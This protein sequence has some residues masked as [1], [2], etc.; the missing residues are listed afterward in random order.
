[1]SKL[2]SLKTVSDSSIFARVMSIDNSSSALDFVAICAITAQRSGLDTSEAAISNESLYVLIRAIQTNKVT[3]AEEALGNLTRRKLKT[4]DTWDKWL[5]GE[6]KQ[7]DQFHDLEMFGPP[8]KLPRDGI[9]LRPHW[10]YSVKCDGERR[11]RNCCDGSKR[12]APL[13]HAL[14]RTY[15][16]CMGQPVQRLFLALSA[17]LNHKLK[18]HTHIPHP[19]MFR[20]LSPL[21][22]P[23]LTGIN[24]NLEPRLTVRTYCLS[25]THSKVIPNPVAYGK[26]TL[27]Q[28]S[29]DLTSISNPR[30]TTVA[31]TELLSR[32][33][34]SSSSDKSTI[35]L[36]L[37]PPNRLPKISLKSLATNFVS[38]TNP[39]S[40]SNI[41]ALPLI[42]TV[43]ISSKQT[44]TSKSL[45]PTTLIVSHAHTAGIHLILPKPSASPPPRFPTKLPTLCT[46][47]LVPLKALLT[48]NV[49]NKNT[50]SF[51]A[52]SLANFYMHTSL[53]NPTLDSPSL[54]SQNSPLLLPQH[55][56]ASSKE[57]PL[58]SA[59][60][61]IRVFD[62]ENPL[63]TLTSNPATTR[64]LHSRL[65]QSAPS[66]MLSTETYAQPGN[67]QMVLLSFLLVPQLCTNLK[68]KLKL[69][70]ALLKQNSM[71]PSPP[72]R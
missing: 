66:W 8:I 70:S 72:L 53:V 47:P 63:R 39:S 52:L 55:I 45:A 16:S 13:F 38:P 40:P 64:I 71:S 69:P 6:R 56:I 27:T 14:A 58:T 33:I 5:A 44:T 41:L 15:S 29:P 65:F 48:T 34:M 43:L 3:P 30:Y 49:S 20:Y 31:Y 23:M 60:R 51:F 50:D 19:L 1:M 57:S 28:S 9:L 7:L 10:Q 35:S 26:N 18:M 42:I 11:S 61:V 25:N 54:P 46:A 24:G 59:E 22:A 21:T 37:V 67:Q 4:L 62:T 17:T 68:P 36:S 32:A 12:A 2:L